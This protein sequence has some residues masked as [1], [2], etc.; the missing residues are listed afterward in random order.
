MHEREVVSGMEVFVAVVEGGSLAAAARRTGLTSSA[1][2][3]LVARLERGFGAPLLRRTTRSM[4]VTDAGAPRAIEVGKSA[5]E[6]E[7][8][9]S[10]STLG[11]FE[12]AIKREGLK[13]SART[14]ERAGSKRVGARGVEIGSRAT[15]SPPTQLNH[16][17]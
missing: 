9:R 5:S 2:S 16:R 14:V 7:C 11:V 8:K 4:T 17:A 13:V 1:V 6:T 3:K 10:W 15:R 12:R